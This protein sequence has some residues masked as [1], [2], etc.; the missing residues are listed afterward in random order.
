MTK[1]SLAP[2]VDHDGESLGLELVRHRSSELFVEPVFADFHGQVAQLFNEAYVRTAFRKPD[3]RYSWTLD[4]M[5]R[6]SNWWDAW[7]AAP[8]IDPLLPDKLSDALRDTLP[9]FGI[10]PPEGPLSSTVEGYRLELWVRVSPTSQDR[11]LVRWA[12]SESR[13]LEGVNG[14]CGRLEAPSYLASV[15]AFTEGRPRAF[16]IADLESGRESVTR[17]TSKSFLGIPIRVNDCIVGVL[18]LAAT[19]HLSQTAM[20]RR[21]ASTAEAVEYLKNVGATLLDA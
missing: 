2:D 1:A 18:S 21:D 11:Q 9:L 13:I 8:G 5:T 20:L 6:L 15:R 10:A 3:K 7:V 4:Y 16:D 17:Y 12:T 14:K 19:S